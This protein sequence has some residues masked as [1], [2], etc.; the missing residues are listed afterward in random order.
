MAVPQLRER[1]PDA[2]AASASSGGTDFRWPVRGRVI[3]GFGA[4]PNG[5]TNDGVNISVPEGTRD[6]GGR[7]RR[8][9]LCRQ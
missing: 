9:G 2:P 1:E 3:S 8:R 4:K 7:R 6:Q 5:Q